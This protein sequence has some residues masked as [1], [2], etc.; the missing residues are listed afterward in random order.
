MS[1]PFSSG[2][3]A[4]QFSCTQ[5]TV[6][7][8]HELYSELI[9]GGKEIVF[10]WVPGHVGISFNS[11]VDSA[12]KDSLEGEVADKYIPFVRFETTFEKLHQ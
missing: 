7:K 12:A 9:R 4:D 2:N 10:V 3:N 8:I 11:A 5:S 6:I 1:S